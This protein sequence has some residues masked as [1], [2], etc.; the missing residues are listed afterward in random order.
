MDN[1]CR[2]RLCLLEL[3]LQKE[4]TELVKYLSAV[5]VPFRA[6]S[7][8]EPGTNPEPTRNRLGTNSKPTANPEP[9]RDLPGEAGLVPGWFRVGSV[10]VPS[11]SG[12]VP[13]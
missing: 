1:S 7:G 6:P 9:P 12:L 4:T 5:S 2:L 3:R 10:S 8:L 11:R 13:G